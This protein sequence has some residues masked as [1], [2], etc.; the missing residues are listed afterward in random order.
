LLSQ[1]QEAFPTHFFPGVSENI[2]LFL[3]AAHF[4]SRSLSNTIKMS[5]LRLSKSASRLCTLR[6][7][8]ASILFQQKYVRPA[9]A[10]SAYSRFSHCQFI[11]HYISTLPETKDTNSILEFLNQVKDDSKNIAYYNDLLKQLA[12]KGRSLQAQ[13]VYDEIFREHDLQANITTYSQLMLA[14]INDGKYEEAMEI[15]YELRDHEDSANYAVKNLRLDADTYASMIQSLTDP[16]NMVLHGNQFDP[17]AE[18]L[19]EYSVEDVDSAIYQDIEGNS[20][21]ALLTALTLFNDMRHLEIQPTSQ[22]YNS[23]LKACAGQK[24]GYVL[25]KLHK[26]I[27]MDLYLDPDIHV[28]YHLMNA[29]SVV[30]DGASVLEIW[31]SMAEHSQHFDQDGISIVLKTCLDNGYKS[32]AKAIWNELSKSKNIKMPINDFNNYL[33]SQLNNSQD[34]E[35]L[36]E[37]EKL[38]EQGLSNGQANET[39]VNLLEKHKQNNK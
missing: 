26:L 9:A 34:K 36:E 12:V 33:L 8:Q 17:I 7:R 32:R 3:M 30:G 16:K 38:V 11:R 15:Y 31:D 23:M 28:F 1:F 22:M 18:P 6:Q 2:D 10:V 21:P 25:E 24:D 39:S 19:Y 29:Y 5:L 20:Q 4:F 27:R 14:Y 13:K 37:I 35:Q